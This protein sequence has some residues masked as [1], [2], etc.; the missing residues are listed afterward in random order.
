MWAIG[1]VASGNELGLDTAE[2][3]ALTPTERAELVAAGKA[4]M[5]AAGAHYAIDSVADL[6][7]V[8]REIDARIGKGEA[9]PL[10]AV[11]PRAS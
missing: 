10:P 3:A 11:K 6:P 5:L 7:E 8:L 1:A 9:P 2:L 4:R